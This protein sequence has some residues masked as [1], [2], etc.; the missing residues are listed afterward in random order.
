MTEYAVRF[1][2][3]AA[4]DVIDYNPNKIDPTNAQ[5]VDN[6][7]GVRRTWQE[8]CDIPKDAHVVFRYSPDEPW[9]RLARYGTCSGCNHDMALNEKMMIPVH[10]AASG[11]CKGG[12][13]YPTALRPIG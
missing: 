13:R 6:W 10:P 8:G 3:E 11:P 1:T 7:A 4:R 9:Q 5:A 12:D 2:D